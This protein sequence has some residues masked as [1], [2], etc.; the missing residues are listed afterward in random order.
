M[1][2][3]YRLLATDAERTR[4]RSRYPK[5]ARI[6]L[7]FTDDPYTRLTPG[8]LGTVDNVDDAGTVHVDWDSGE[9]LGLVP[10]VDSFVLVALPDDEHAGSARS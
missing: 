1:E 3:P 5:G 9:R 7:T 8:T 10:D 2:A 4:L 6:R